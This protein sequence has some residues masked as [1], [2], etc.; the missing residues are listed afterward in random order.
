M[1]LKITLSLPLE[2]KAR[3]FKIRE[4]GERSREETKEDGAPLPVSSIFCITQVGLDFATV[5]TVVLT[6]GCCHH[7]L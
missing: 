7:W 2:S 3:L 5:K 6:H 1:K 4:E